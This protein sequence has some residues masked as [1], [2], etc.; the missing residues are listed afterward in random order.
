MLLHSRCSCVSGIQLNLS[1]LITLKYAKLSWISNK[2]AFAFSVFVCVWN[3]IQ[4]VKSNNIEIRQIE[5]N[6]EQNCVCIFF[7]W[8]K[9]V[10]FINLDKNEKSWIEFQ[11]TTRTKNTDAVLFEIQLNLAYFNVIRF[12]K[13]NWL[14][15]KNVRYKQKSAAL[16]GLMTLF[17]L[18]IFVIDIPP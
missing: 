4:F 2:N 12:D 17:D 10:W 16:N 3:L 5:L 8:M 7:S 15:D 6:F 18:L 1:N 13:L 9:G 11:T 14:P